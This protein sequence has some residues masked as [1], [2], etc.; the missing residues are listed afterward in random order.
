MTA[1][2]KKHLLLLLP[3]LVV[4]LA[5]LPWGAVLSF[6]VMGD[7]GEVV[8]L[9]QT[10]S[11]FSL[12]PFGY[13][14]FGPLLT[15]VCACVLA[16]LGLLFFLRGK[17]L[18]AIRVVSVI[19]VVTSVMPLFLGMSLYSLLGAGISLVLLANAVVAFV[20]PRGR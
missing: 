17:A 18:R 5:A 15:A 8:R 13:A 4:V 6:G 19:A 1:N 16:V 3:I 12:T 7:A 9:R 20:T 10:Y 11:Y 14:N 2:L